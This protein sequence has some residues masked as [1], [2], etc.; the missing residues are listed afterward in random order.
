MGLCEDEENIKKHKYCVVNVDYLAGRKR[1]LMGEDLSR[2]KWQEKN[3]A[4]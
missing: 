3:S 2:T 4:L 1:F